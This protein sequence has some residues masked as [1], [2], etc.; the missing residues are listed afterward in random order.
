MKAAPI[1][2]S[3]KPHLFLLT[4]RSIRA[5]NKKILQIISNTNLHLPIRSA[6]LPQK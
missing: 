5:I 6:L 3:L 4:G 2:H 1:S